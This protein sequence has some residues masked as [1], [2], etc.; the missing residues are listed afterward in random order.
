MKIQSAVAACSIFV[1]ASAFAQESPNH[2]TEYLMTESWPETPLIMLGSTMLFSSL[3]PSHIV[4]IASSNRSDQFLWIPVAGPW[5]DLADRGNGPVTSTT[6]LLVADGIVQAVSALL[7]IAG[8]VPAVARISAPNV[9]L[10]PTG[11]AGAF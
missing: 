8:L 9:H 3:L 10:T 1:C 2:D 5:L 7:I 6:V 11:V 4:A